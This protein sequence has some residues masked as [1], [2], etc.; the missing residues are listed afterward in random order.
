[1]KQLFLE[2]KKLNLP[3]MHFDRNGTEMIIMQID[4][5]NMIAIEEGYDEF[6][7]C[8][9]YDYRHGKIIDKSNTWEMME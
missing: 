9:E 7:P 6:Y 1:M 5:G 8:D 3:A 2:M 4:N